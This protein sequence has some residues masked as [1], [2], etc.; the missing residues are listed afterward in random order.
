MI[1]F[2]FNP[3]SAFYAP[4]SRPHEIRARFFGLVSGRPA[5]LHFS[6]CFETFPFP[7]NWET[8]PA[9]EAAGKAYHDFR[10]ALMVRN[11]EGMTRIYNR[12][13]VMSRYTPTP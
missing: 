5:S 9:L 10:T 4:Q 11:D 7:E 13:H 2:P 8:H 3:R 1:T 6:G 12:F